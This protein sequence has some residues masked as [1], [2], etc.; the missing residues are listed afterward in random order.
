MRWKLS[1]YLIILV[2]KVVAEFPLDANSI[3]CEP[4]PRDGANWKVN[5][6]NHQ[7][8]DIICTNNSPYHATSVSFVV[9]NADHI[10]KT[11]NL[12]HNN[13][14]GDDVITY[15]LTNPRKAIHPGQSF[16]GAGYVVKGSDIPE[17]VNVYAN[18]ETVMNE[19]STPCSDAGIKI[20]TVLESTG[21]INGEI[22]TLYNIILENTKTHLILSIFVDIIPTEGSRID[23]ETLIEI[24]PVAG[25]TYNLTF[26]DMLFPG[27]VDDES[28]FK[29]IG[30]GAV[31]ITCNRLDMHTGAVVDHRQ[32]NVAVLLIGIS[33][34]SCLFIATCAIV[35]IFIQK[36][37]H[38]SKFTMK[39]L[40]EF[41]TRRSTEYRYTKLENV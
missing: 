24:D 2:W 36:G 9:N 17:I 38:K 39:N 35:V 10:T 34:G 15:H 6:I 13:E 5:D 40:R 26:E 33:V 20:T 8:Y 29:L 19:P 3:I 12:V 30:P 4:Q 22:E 7:L 23:R 37:K 25:N 41:A 21:Y 11:W 27:R 31:T 18:G 16:G 14:I 32:K 28:T 1:L